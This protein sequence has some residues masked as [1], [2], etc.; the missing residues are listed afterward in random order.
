VF[1]IKVM[2][3]KTPIGVK[4]NLDIESNVEAYEAFYYNAVQNSLED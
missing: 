2:Q 4:P 1:D 3:C